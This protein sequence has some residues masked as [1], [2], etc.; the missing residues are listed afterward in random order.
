MKK[1][2]FRSVIH[3]S[4]FATRYS[5]FYPN[6]SVVMIWGAEAGVWEAFLGLSGFPFFGAGPH[7]GTAV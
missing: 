7:G 2:R 3:T 4:L 1:R 6:A 5:P